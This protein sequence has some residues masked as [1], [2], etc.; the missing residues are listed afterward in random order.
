M[1]ELST[2]LRQLDA[3]NNY[4]S[5]LYKCALSI[6][7]R[8]LWMQLN[9]NLVSYSELNFIIPIKHSGYETMRMRAVILDHAV[10][11]ANYGA[12]KRYFFHE[13]SCGNFIHSTSSANDTTTADA[14]HSPYLWFTNTYLRLRNYST[15]TSTAPAT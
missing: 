13:K 1:K 15:I 4:S 11:T 9:H 8:F 2:T 14:I 12:S 6:Y 5:S 7:H 3:I 10:P